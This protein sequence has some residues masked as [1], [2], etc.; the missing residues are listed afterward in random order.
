VQRKIWND[1]IGAPKTEA[2]EAGIYV[3]SV[4]RKILTK[5]RSS[6]PPVGDGWMFRGGKLLRP[7]DLDNI[8]RREIPQYINSAWFGWHAF[9]RGLGTRLNEAGV[10]DKDI[11][12]ILRHADVSTTQAYYILPNHERAQAGMKKLDKTLRTKY[13]IKG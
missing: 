13:G 9:R 2:R 10:D 1:Y 4:L 8:S 12:S 5:Y 3:I 6:F 11:Q 7:L